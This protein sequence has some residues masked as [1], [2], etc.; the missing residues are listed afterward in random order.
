M[1][2]WCLQQA[3]LQKKN[4]TTQKAFIPFTPRLAGIQVRNVATYLGFYRAKMSF[5]K[6]KIPSLQCF[7]GH[8]SSLSYTASSRCWDSWPVLN[9]KQP[10]RRPLSTWTHVL[11]NGSSLTASLQRDSMQVWASMDVKYHCQ[12]TLL[13][14]VFSASLL[15]TIDTQ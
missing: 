9:N 14:A 2:D 11:G 1:S 4:I 6:Y 12:S 8:C 5:H 7:K 10:A 3:H 15:G 13:P